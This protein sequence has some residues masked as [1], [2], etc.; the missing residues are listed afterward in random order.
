MSASDHLSPQQFFHASPHAFEP[1]DMV[2]PGHNAVFRYS[3]GIRD[4]LVW[5]TASRNNAVQW[6]RSVGD[7][8]TDHQRGH[9]YEVEPTG[10][11]SPDTN[12]TGPREFES[13][14]PL[15]VV[16]KVSSHRPR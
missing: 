2:E 4:H 1:G 9:V 10:H 6:A 15:R 16:R 11:Y 8:D 7:A 14:H 5:F 12:P 13:E 3:G